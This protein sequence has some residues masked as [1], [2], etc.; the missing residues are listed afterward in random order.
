[1]AAFEG[2]SQEVLFK[3][4][5][6]AR[7]SLRSR[8]LDCYGICNPAKVRSGEAERLVRK[9]EGQEGLLLRRVQHKYG[10]D[11]VQCRKCW[12]WSKAK[13]GDKAEWT[14][15][16]LTL[17]AGDGLLRI[18]RRGKRSDRSDR[19]SS[20]QQL[21][22]KKC[23]V[24]ISDSE[25]FEKKPTTKMHGLIVAAVGVSRL[26]CFE[27]AAERDAMSL[28]LRKTRAFFDRIE[29]EQRVR[30]ENARNEELALR[31]SMD[32][33]QDDARQ[34]RKRRD[35]DATELARAAAFSQLPADRS[36]SIAALCASLEADVDEALVFAA[37]ADDLAK[38]NDAKNAFDAYLKSVAAF[39]KVK[40]T[41]EKLPPEHRP[42]A[43]VVALVDRG[44]R[45]CKHAAATLLDRSTSQK[46]PRSEEDS[47]A[48]SDSPHEA[49]DPEGVGIRPGIASIDRTSD[50]LARLPPVVDKLIVD[51]EDL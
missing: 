40:V 43:P 21:D 16:E 31:A 15:A 48:S 2:D 44:T 49:P 22:A 24:E 3:V 34:R 5:A 41:V 39:M 12:V 42:E 1:M 45:D 50:G 29:S 13:A 28:E 18:E 7:E 10:L 26:F 46:Y 6:S 35:E 36:L 30:A 51:T 9:Y 38:K 14:L 23:V 37:Q 25:H 32:S 47:S 19:E 33:A 11:V 8:I 4:A 20:C 17:N 27:T